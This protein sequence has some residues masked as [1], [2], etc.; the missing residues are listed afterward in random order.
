MP[1]QSR[2]SSMIAFS[3]RPTG[4]ELDE[5]EEMIKNGA[6]RVDREGR[7]IAPAGLQERALDTR[8]HMRDERH[9]FDILL[10]PLNHQ[11]WAAFHLRPESEAR[12]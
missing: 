11:V 10:D 4:E 3:V 9:R 6:E 12:K 8:P 2:Y 1:Y 5:A 7:I